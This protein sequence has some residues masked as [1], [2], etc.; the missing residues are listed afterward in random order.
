MSEQDPFEQQRVDRVEDAG[1]QPRGNTP[2]GDQRGRP[3]RR[4][5]EDPQQDQLLHDLARQDTGQRRHEETGGDGARRD[6]RDAE[7]RP[8]EG[9]AGYEHHVVGQHVAGEQQWPDNDDGERGCGE[10]L[11]VSTELDAEELRPQQEALVSMA[12]TGY[13]G[14]RDGPAL[15]VNLEWPT[16]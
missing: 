2:R 4:Q 1:S 16:G 15:D 5:A 9:G 10:C 14:R 6:R 12:G 3:I 11:W 8:A 13:R 7:Q